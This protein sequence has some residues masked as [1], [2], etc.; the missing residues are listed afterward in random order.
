M[1]AP[2]RVLYVDDEPSLLSIG[3]MFLASGDA[4]K[5]LAEE[6]GSR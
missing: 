1:T 6:H 3:K 4:S 5:S 2:F